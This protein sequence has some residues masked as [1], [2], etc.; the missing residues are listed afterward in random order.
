MTTKTNGATKSRMEEEL[1]GQPKQVKGELVVSPRQEIVQAKQDA[2]IAVAQ[3]KASAL[4]LMAVA[5]QQVLAT[6]NP[7]TQHICSLGA[8][9]VSMGGQ[10]EY[11]ET[12]EWD[13][14]F[15]Q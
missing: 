1:F 6:V 4:E 5:G 12:I 11:E 9:I 14:H 10:F 13:N 7:T 3:A 8:Q 2:Q 15:T